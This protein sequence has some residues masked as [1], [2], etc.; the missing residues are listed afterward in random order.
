MKMKNIYYRDNLFILFFILIYSFGVQSGFQSWYSYGLASQNVS[1]SFGGLNPYEEPQLIIAASFSQ[2]STVYNYTEPLYLNIT[3]NETTVLSY[4]FKGLQPVIQSFSMCKYASDLLQ[5][6]DINVV[7]WTNSVIPYNLSF[8]SV[9]LLETVFH[10]QQINALYG[11]CPLYVYYAVDLPDDQF[12]Y[13]IDIHVQDYSLQGTFSNVFMK[14]KD[15]PDPE[16][17]IYD[18]SVNV[19]SGLDF[20][21]NNEAIAGR[22]Y[23]AFECVNNISTDYQ[24]VSQL[25]ATCSKV[26]ITGGNQ[27]NAV[28]DCICDRFHSGTNCTNLFSGVYSVLAITAF[29][30]IFFL[31]LISYKIYQKKCQKY[32]EYINIQSDE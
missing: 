32:P 17:G 26:C 16:N 2:N 1:L 8:V 22:Y 11:F 6:Y 30:I 28:N 9:A 24:L 27:C 7:V 31:S 5:D 3:T 14:A 25:T 18:Q 29:V 19:S 20:V 4:Q 12:A 23:F 13:D 21:F 15:C 10:G